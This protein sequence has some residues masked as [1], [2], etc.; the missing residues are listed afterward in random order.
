MFA[1]AYDVAP[2]GAPI[3]AAFFAFVALLV[4]APVVSA[5]SPRLAALYRAASEVEV[6]PPAVCAAWGLS[7]R[8]RAAW[9]A[10]CASA[11]WACRSDRAFRAAC[12]RRAA[13]DVHSGQTLLEE[14]GEVLREDERCG[15]IPASTR[16]MLREEMR[17]FRPSEKAVA[18][19][20]SLR[21][22][23]RL[24]RKFLKVS[25]EG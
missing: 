14:W 24:W 15:Y 2:N 7:L 18:R 19:A 8:V 1:V 11:W 5:L 9:V 6:R 21:G 23:P 25:K 22:K 17:R 10:E 12:L 13:S 16:L 20:R 4:V 3:A